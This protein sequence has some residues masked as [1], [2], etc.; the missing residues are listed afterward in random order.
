ML[1]RWARFRL[2]KYFKPIP[3][4]YA[5]QRKHKLTK[6]Y[7]FLAWNIIGLTL[8]SVLRQNFPPTEAEEKDT[9]QMVDYIE[10]PG[11]LIVDGQVVVK[12]KE[13]NPEIHS[14]LE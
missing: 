2:R 12:K 1:W 14:K 5:Q 4:A 11:E 10:E 9:M 3:A 8:Y 13:L 6:I 7:T